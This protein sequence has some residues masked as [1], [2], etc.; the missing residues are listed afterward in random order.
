MKNQIKYKTLFLLL[1]VFVLW[2]VVPVPQQAEDLKDR[3]DSI[4]HVLGINVDNRI[5]EEYAGKEITDLRL[6]IT[7]GKASIVWK[8]ETG[9]YVYSFTDLFSGMELF[10]QIKKSGIKTF[11]AKKEGTEV[12]FKK[13]YRV[14]AFQ[15]AASPDD[16]NSEGNY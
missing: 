8:F 3:P 7:N 2:W 4:M 6:Y 5:L 15:I 13:F 9:F 12:K 11:I 1:S 10:K 14:I 16:G